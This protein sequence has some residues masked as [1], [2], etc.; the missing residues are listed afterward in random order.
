MENN[1]ILFYIHSTTDKGFSSW[2][3]FHKVAINHPCTVFF[4]I[5]EQF[6]PNPGKHFED[7]FTFGIQNQK[8]I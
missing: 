6:T 1:N 5:N 3:M 8:L 4:F 2:M 7:V